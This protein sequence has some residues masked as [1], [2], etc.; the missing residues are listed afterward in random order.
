MTTHDWIQIIILLLFY[1]FGR[2]NGY[3]AAKK[4][5]RGF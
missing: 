2:W 1:L 3:V 4:K 5:Y